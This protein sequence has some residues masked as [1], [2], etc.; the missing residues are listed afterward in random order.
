MDLFFFPFCFFF[1]IATK[2]YVNVRESKIRN[3]LKS[4][5]RAPVNNSYHIFIGAIVYLAKF[6]VCFRLGGF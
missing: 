5:N 2:I 6:I 3:I 1:I 4:S